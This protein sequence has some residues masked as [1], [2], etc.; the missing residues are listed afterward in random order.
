MMQHGG[1][2]EFSPIKEGWEY[3]IST[4]AALWRKDFLLEILRDDESAWDFE[5]IGSARYNR[6]Y[7]DKG[8]KI[9]I[10]RGEFPAIF[11]Y[12]FL[13]GYGYGIVAGKWQRKNIELFNKYG[14]SV[15]FSKR[16]FIEDIKELPEYSIQDRIKM[17]IKREV[18]ALKKR[19][20]P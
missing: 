9:Y 6:K 14:I 15:D 19:Y 10:H 2:R 13:N 7:F 16:G 20:K 5:G 17:K 18:Y 3:T 11:D 8:K 12:Q 4:Q 1:G